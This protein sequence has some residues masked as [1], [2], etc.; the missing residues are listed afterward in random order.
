MEKRRIPSNRLRFWFKTG[1]PGQSLL[2]KFARCKICYPRY[3]ICFPLFLFERNHIQTKSTSISVYSCWLCCSHI[4][5][6]TAFN[7]RT[8]GIQH[9]LFHFS[10]C[11]NF[12]GFILFTNF[13]KKDGQILQFRRSF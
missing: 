10:N 5:S 2:E 8:I 12:Y 7:F 4:L 9:G 1:N 6:F 13:F 11:R 3:F